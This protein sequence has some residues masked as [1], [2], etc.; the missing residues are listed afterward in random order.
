MGIFSFFTK[1]I[2]PEGKVF[3]SLISSGLI[4]WNICLRSRAD[5]VVFGTSQ[6]ERVSTFVRAFQGALFAYGERLMLGTVYTEEKF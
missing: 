6:N 1:Q 2:V 3:K 4:A 5:A